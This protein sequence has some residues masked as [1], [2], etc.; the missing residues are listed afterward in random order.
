MPISLYSITSQF[1]IHQSLYHSML[2][3]LRSYRNI[4]THKISYRRIIARLSNISLIK[5]LIMIM[6]HKMK[7]TIQ[8]DSKWRDRENNDNSPQCVCDCNEDCGSLFEK[9]MA[10][11]LV[12]KFLTFYW[13]SPIYYRF[14]Q[15]AITGTNLIKSPTSR[16][17]IAQSV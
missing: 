10:A 7:Q 5:S 8:K 4:T 15:D 14:S 9:L 12:R 3:T 17:G 1:I 13:N 11:G 16:P 6:Y 2:H